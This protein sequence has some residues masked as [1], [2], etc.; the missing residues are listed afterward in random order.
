VGEGNNSAELCRWAC[1]G[2]ACGQ[3]WTGETIAPRIAMA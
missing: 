3:F 1:F 2:A